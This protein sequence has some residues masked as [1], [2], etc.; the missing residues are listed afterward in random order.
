MFNIL[1]E[2]PQFDELQFGFGSLAYPDSIPK[3][4]LDFWLDNGFVFSIFP[5]CMA[6]V[7]FFVIFDNKEGENSAKRGVTKPLVIAFACFII[8]YPFPAIMVLYWTMSIVLQWMEKK[9]LSQGNISL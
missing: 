6:L 5:L 1:G 4:Q 2:M 8:F 3:L 9:F 7:Y